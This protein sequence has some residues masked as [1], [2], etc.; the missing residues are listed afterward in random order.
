MA[1][2]KHNWDSNKPERE[3]TLIISDKIKM[4]GTANQLIRELIKLLK[5]EH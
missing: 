5:N 3:Y 2:N 4:M 1:G